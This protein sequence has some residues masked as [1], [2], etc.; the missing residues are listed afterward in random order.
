M[1]ATVVETEALLETVAAALI[2]GVGITAAFAILV[3]GATRSADMA[4]DERPVL[5]F[6]TGG[7]AVIALLAVVASIVVGIVLMAQE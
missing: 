5:A 7:L 1:L 4:R 3:F 2:S 6:A